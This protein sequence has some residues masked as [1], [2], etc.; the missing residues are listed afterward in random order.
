MATDPEFAAHCTE[1]PTLVGLLGADAVDHHHA[2]DAAHGPVATRR[3]DP[4]AARGAD[5]RAGQGR[6]LA[7]RASAAA[8]PRPAPS[9]ATG[10]PRLGGPAASAARHM[11]STG[12]SR[13]VHEASCAAAW[14]TSMPSPSSAVAPA[15]RR[16]GQP[17]RRAGARRRGRPPPGPGRAAPG[18]TSHCAPAGAAARHADRR[19][20]DDQVG[21]ADRLGRRTPRSAHD[22]ARRAGQ[23]G[24]PARPLGCPVD[25]GHLGWRRHRPAPARPPAPRRRRRRPGSAGRPGRSRRPG[26]ATRRSPR[27]RCW[28]PHERAVLVDDAVDGVRGGAPRR[29]TRRPARPPSA[30]CGMVTESPRIPARRI[31]S[32]APRA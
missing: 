25:D 20:V 24:R 13:P 18:G 10:Q 3:V 4:G 2:R 14:W 23:C 27:R 12:G 30:L 7:G 26:P 17:R 9:T 28:S 29:C 31:A 6:A 22:R 19:G 11:A 5:R 32:S 8:A 21:D 16:L 15:G 1:P